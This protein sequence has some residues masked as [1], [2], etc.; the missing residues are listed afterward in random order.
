V[1]GAGPRRA[2]RR[3]ALAFLLIV[4]LVV[5]VVAAGLFPQAWVSDWAE[6]RLRA[7]LGPDAQVGAVHVVPGLLRAEVS[8]LVLV[9]PA[10]RLEV[11]RARVR[12]SPAALWTRRL[13]VE[14][15]E[16]DRPRLELR[17]A[18]A[19]T[20]AQPVDG[21]LVL[22]RIAITDGDVTYRDP[23]LGGDVHVGG[24]SASGSV[25]SGTLLVEA[26]GGRWDRPQP[27]AVGP[28]RVRLA[29]SP[30]LDVKVEE[31]HVETARSRLD[32]RGAI[33]RIG[34]PRP[35]LD[36]AGRLDLEEIGAALGGPPS[37]GVLSATGH[38]GTAG[39]TLV[40]AATVEAH[41]VRLGGW[42]LDRIEVKA[43]YRG[44]AL[45][46][47]T[48]RIDANAFGGRIFG[49]ART[50]GAQAKATLRAVAVDLAALAHASGRDDIPAGT[51]SVELSVEGDLRDNVTLEGHADA[52]LRAASLDARLAAELRGTVRVSPPVLALTWNARLDG[53]PAA[54]G[55]E[56]PVAGLGLTADGMVRGPLPP[57]VEG[58]IDGAATLRGPAG[59]EP[60]ALSGPFHSEGGAADVAL[61]A[62]GLGGTARLTVA[63]AGSNL[64]RL[65]C[66]AAG[67][68]IG[69]LAAAAAGTSAVTLHAS[70]PLTAP[71][72][73]AEVRVAD[74]VVRGV[75]AGA[76]TL[77]AEGTLDRAVL[78]AE[79]PDL[80]ARLRGEALLATNAPRRVRGTLA[81][82][83]TPLE[84]LSTLLPGER[85]LAG[86]VSASV[87]FDVPLADAAAATVDARVDRLTARSEPFEAAASSF[88]VSYRS[89]KLVVEGLTVE[90]S[91]VRLAVSGSAA[92]DAA[93]PLDLHAT[94]DADLARVPARTAFTLAGT[95]H[96]DVAIAGTRTAPRVTG[97]VRLADVN[98]ES[99]AIG[100]V[101]IAEGEVALDGD[102]LRTSGLVA[103]VSGGTVTLSGSVPLPALVVGLRHGTLAPGE[104]A[105]LRVQWA[106]VAVSRVG[107]T[108]QGEARMEGGLASLAEPR[109]TVTVPATPLKIQDLDFAVEPF[110][111]RLERGRLATDAISL[112]R[113]ESALRLGG[114]VDLVRRE[115]DLTARG[116]LELRALSPFLEEAALTGQLSIDAAA[117]GSIDA[118]RLRGRVD[119]NDGTL[120]LRQIPQPLTEIRASVALLG[121]T[122]RIE[123][124]TA[125]FGGG[126]VSLS[127]GM[128]LAGTAASDVSLVI[129]GRDIALR[130]PE[131]LRS[132]LN[133]DLTLAGKPGSFTLGGEVHV[134]RGLFDLD[135]ALSSS[136]T[137]PVVKP[138]ESPLLRSIALDI[139]VAIDN[140]VLVRN[141]LASVEA[142]GRLD[143]RGD[144]MEPAPFGRVDLVP[145]GKVYLQGR[146][147]A[148][149]GGG[150]EYSGSW[151][152]S[153]DVA[154]EARIR[155][156][157][158]DYEIT[159]SAAGTLLEPRLAFSSDPP[160][161]EREIVNVIAIGRRE[162]SETD[163][164][165]WM[166]GGQAG[167]LLAGRLTRGVAEKVGLEEIS[168]RPELRP[169]L[170][171]REVTPGARFTFGKR[172][173]PQVELVYSAGLG[174]PE[175]RFT[176]LIVTPGRGVTL[177]GQRDDTGLVTGGVGQRFELGGV[178][179]R[180]EPRR[181]EPKVEL[182]EVRLKVDPAE[183]EPTVRRS[184]DLEKGRRVTTWQVQ[185]EADA[186]RERLRKDGYIEAEA[187]ARVEAGVASI[188]VHAGARYAWRVA[189]MDDPP[190][191]A[192]VVEGALFE[193]E[194]LDKGRERLLAVL[195]SRGHVYATVAGRGVDEGGRRVLVFEASPGRRV[196]RVE[197]RF[198]GAAVLSPSTLERAAGGPATILT[199]WARAADGIRAAYR[200]RHYLAVEIG[201]P[202]VQEARDG[203]LAVTIPIAEGQAASTASIAFPGATRPVDE[204][205]RVA[206]IGEG[207]RYDE[208]A[209]TAAAGRLRDHYLGLGYPAIRVRV[210]VEEAGA[211]YAVA[212]R[213]AEGE[214]VTIGDIAIEGL[215]RTKASR[216]RAQLGFASGQPL[217]PRLLAAAERR[218]QNLGSFAR[219]T[220][221]VEDGNPAPLRVT[222]EELAPF[223]GTYDLRYNDEE[224]GTALADAEAR[225]LFGLGLAVGGRYRAGADVR[226]ARGSIRVPS[227]VR[228]GDF[229]GAVFS[230]DEDFSIEDVEITRRQRGFQLQQ[231]VHLV[232][233]WVLLAGYRYRV[234]TTISPFLP[235]IPEHT[236]G[237]ETSLLRD[238]RDNPLDTRRGRFWS[239]NL[240]YAPAFLG[241]DAP[242]VK[243]FAQ[244]FVSRPLS[245]TLTWA[246]G[247]RLGLAHGF[248]GQPL[249]PFE[250]F[251]AGGGSSLRGYANGSVGPR[252]VFGDSVGGEA[253]VVVNEELRYHGPS[254]FG[255]AVF[256]DVG[257]VF[258]TVRDMSFDLRHTL[259]VGARWIS[260]IGLVRLDLGIPLNREDG[261]KA[262][263]LSFSIGQAF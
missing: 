191:L 111:V 62:R 83:D 98:A 80:A 77:T 185:E 172:L 107:A 93:G 205:A 124:G 203:A 134:V 201:A 112:R 197:V 200:V 175:E 193:E 71:A 103:A 78:A 30:L 81:L 99:A 186:L 151:D 69:R 84:P 158:A 109:V 6:A 41:A 135:V 167:A 76:A 4:V 257:N 227:L 121:D 59:L 5:I 171:A 235:E 95:T 27:L 176:Q 114:S 218:L 164:G 163:T 1:T 223:V 63:V 148:V 220:I 156:D 53:K 251:T 38:V 17:P 137:A 55:A 262:Y 46:R 31:A 209:V 101:R 204:L 261:D 144:M 8:D 70:G 155:A 123:E 217:D 184:L 234:S 16:V 168:V 190:S 104:Q 10:Y 79:I 49:E 100:P 50:H 173:L 212:F 14:E 196:P 34:A 108:L 178:R 68:D 146:A 159:V 242:F 29:V 42:P 230:V 210:E 74:V 247:Y 179:R 48:A 232:N 122:A 138:T 202:T 75:R 256:Y 263:R 153:L 60:I 39:D 61:D 96:A 199:A 192:G 174:G 246:Q 219:A 54:G 126:T 147:F 180:R 32:A 37:K 9:G 64:E 128:A 11:P 236:A 244:A 249:I 12:L 28:L 23:A 40:G 182:T 20:A 66:E 117:A 211:D 157:A 215:S 241:S 206:A 142:E 25:G 2:V 133:A 132:R 113:D 222:L 195:R 216:V 224:K 21:P 253:V 7:S 254:G 198:E 73:R 177:L 183:L 43:D 170:L 33:G 35:D 258:A 154:A 45:A 252:D 245:P 51:G 169:D 129:T 119:L 105:D 255:G 226:E 82:A 238:T 94:L 161:E 118:P 36:V 88:T 87:D 231:T 237:L 110:S 248:N 208:T 58:R 152:P 91:G 72:F 143:F 243:G 18:P 240:E 65:D 233:R 259:G 213:L 187:G 47:A 145:G 141:N 207:A 106:G 140:P 22:R 139:A 125:A 120:R 3:A 92:T 162:A 19:K 131:G 194:A 24:V 150:L 102:A 86:A 165:T 225:N 130:Y 160:L 67:I 181:A 260:P 127:G 90:G 221:K 56:A 116:D 52:D 229:L 44:E 136:L 250:R 26:K 189:G 15:L 13:A 214:A 239:V 115:V 166:A 188:T 97:T 89:S 57:I 149:T 228:G 85:P